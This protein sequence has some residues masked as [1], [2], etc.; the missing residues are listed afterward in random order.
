MSAGPLVPAPEVLKGFGITEEQY[1]NT[2]AYYNG[3]VQRWKS[4]YDD[5][6]RKL[7]EKGKPAGGK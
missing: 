1:R 3:D 7:Q 6:I 5:V 2:V 4:F